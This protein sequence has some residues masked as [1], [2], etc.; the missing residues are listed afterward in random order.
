MTIDECSDDI[1][2]W[3]PPRWLF[4]FVSP[5]VPRPPQVE[6]IDTTSLLSYLSDEQ[7]N[8]SRPMMKPAMQTRPTSPSFFSSTHANKVTTGT[9]K[10]DKNGQEQQNRNREL[11]SVKA[12][13]TSNTSSANHNGKQICHL[14][15]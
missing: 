9:Q 10:Q 6:M 11:A 15:G 1:W 5:S 7:R 14:R 3:T 2:T 8:Q 4:Q 13:D 12:K